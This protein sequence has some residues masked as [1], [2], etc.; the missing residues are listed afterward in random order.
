[1]VRSVLFPWIIRTFTI[2]VCNMSWYLIPNQ[3]K[4]E[5]HGKNKVPS[6]MESWFVRSIVSTL[7]V[8]IATKAVPCWFL[9]CNKARTVQSWRVRIRTFAWHVAFREIHFWQRLFLICKMC[10]IA[11]GAGPSWLVEVHPLPKRLYNTKT[12][13]LN[14]SAGSRTSV[15]FHQSNFAYVWRIWAV[16]VAKNRFFSKISLVWKI[17]SLKS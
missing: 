1:M 16:Q 13:S 7:Q 4:F 14:Q 6:I 2:L 10:N 12:L 11:I 8:P 9:M 15:F 5:G 3:E 17:R